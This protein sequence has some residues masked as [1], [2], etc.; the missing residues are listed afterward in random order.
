MTTG[1]GAIPAPQDEV[2]SGRYAQG[3]RSPIAYVYLCPPCG[4]YAPTRM[5]GTQA[6]PPYGRCQGCGCDVTELHRFTAVIYSAE[7]CS[8]RSSH[9]RVIGDLP[10]SAGRY[11]WSLI[12]PPDYV[13]GGP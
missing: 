8:C 2:P 6:D 7:G 11:A 1:L 3:G 9:P 5:T 12:P 10:E 13:T 4:G